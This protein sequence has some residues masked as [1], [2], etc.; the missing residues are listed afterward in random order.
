MSKHT[1]S[2]KEVKVDNLS[3]SKDALETI[4]QNYMDLLKKINDEYIEKGKRDMKK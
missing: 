1:L 4:D 2:K 3:K